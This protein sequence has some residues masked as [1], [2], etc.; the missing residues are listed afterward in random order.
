[1]KPRIAVLASGSGTTAEAFIRASAR[2]QIE[3]EIGLVICNNK[4][5]GIFNRIEI[6]NKELGLNI[7]TLLINS[8]T[9]PDVAEPEPGL[10]TQ[11][12]EAAILKTLQQEKFDLIA[13][14]GYMKKVGPSLVRT[15]GWQFE[16]TDPRQAM[17]VNTHP[18]LLPE[19]KGLYGVHV[20]EYVL[21]KGL[22]F[23]GQTLHLVAENYDDG[24]IIAEHKI[25]VNSDD[26]PESLFD[27]VREI[28]KRY[29]PTDIAAF[30]ETRSKF[31]HKESA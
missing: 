8:K 26:T 5:A 14:M 10:Q 20:Q 19:T 29:L 24:P 22:L 21:E 2:G 12:E 27:R 23:S 1:M 9:H 25:P 7:P 18:G 16:Y 31:N 4:K 28:E 13:L 11:A 6:L 17:M 30:I 3:P 15:F